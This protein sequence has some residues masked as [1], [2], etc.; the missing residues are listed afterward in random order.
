MLALGYSHFDL[1]QRVNCVP[2]DHWSIYWSNNLEWFQTGRCS[3]ALS[4]L[5]SQLASWP[6]LGSAQFVTCAGELI[7]FS[8]LHWWGF[9]IHQVMWLSRSDY[10][11]NDVFFPLGVQAD[12][13]NPVH[14][15]KAAALSLSQSSLSYLGKVLQN[16][17]HWAIVLVYQCFTKWV[18]C[19]QKSIGNTMPIQSPSILT[20]S[21]LNSIDKNYQNRLHWDRSYFIDLGSC[22]FSK[23]QPTSRG[24]H[25]V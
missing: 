4:Q 23:R 15:C 6:A 21:C 20:G 13:L 22:L 5:L 14:V 12:T 7:V 17:L 9:S 11:I 24:D 8:L 16:P 2:F 10:I 1:S 3:C 19:N 25:W 18:T